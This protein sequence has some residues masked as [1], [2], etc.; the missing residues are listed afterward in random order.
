MIFRPCIDIH[1]GKVKQIVGGS[2]RDEG[3]FA[4]ENYVSERSAEDIA[5]MFKEDKVKGAHVIMLNGRDSEYYDVTRE[6]AMSALYAYPG[7]LQIGGGITSLNAKSYI[8]AGAEK[9]IV[10]SFAFSDGEVKYENLEKLVSA[11]GRDRIVLDLSCRFKDGDY[12]IVTDRWQNFTS[13]KVTS[14][15]FSNLSKY[16]SE[17]LVHGVDVEGSKAGID[18]EL[19]K[20]LSEASQNG[21]VI[22][23]AGGISSEDD[24][25]KIEAFSGGRL[26]FTVGSA[27]DIYGGKLSYKMLTEKYR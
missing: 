12:Y 10:T 15:V 6:E 17:F 27:L 21:H 18:E 9:V 7:G 25:K 14:R 5:L 11:V 20:I 2:L 13:V 22:T 16:A 19:I 4:E 3:S 1:N 24:I 26:D 8:D 23:Y